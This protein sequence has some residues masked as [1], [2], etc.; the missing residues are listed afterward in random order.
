MKNLKTK[1]LITSI[2]AFIGIIGFQSCDSDNTESSNAIENSN[3]EFKIPETVSNAYVGG[4]KLPDGTK[5]VKIDDSTVEFTYPKGIELWIGDDNGNVSKMYYSGGYSCTCSGDN[6]CN[7][8]YAGGDFGCSHG[9]C[10]GTCSGKHS[11]IANPKDLNCVFVDTNKKLEPI[12]NDTD[13]EELPYISEMVVKQEKVQKILKEFAKEIYGN[14]YKSFTDRVDNSHLNKS[15]INDI[16]FI[17]MKVYGFKFL[18]GISFNDLK[19][20]VQKNNNF[21]RVYYGGGHSCNCDSGSSGCEK[22]SSIGVKY[23][24]GG[25]CTTCTMT[26]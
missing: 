25:S 26:L 23:C 6:G 21:N 2:I 17:K 10:S 3:E 1:L 14:N 20:E 19:P 9:S 15:D 7:V 24:K 5:V 18:Y 12:N 22:G 13:F 11:K 4:L 8:F 16:V